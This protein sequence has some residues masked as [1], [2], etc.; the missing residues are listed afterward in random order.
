MEE[1]DTNTME[2]AHNIGAGPFSTNIFSVINLSDLSYLSLNLPSSS[3]K[4]SSHLFPKPPH[5]IHSGLGQSL[6]CLRLF[7]V[8]Y[9]MAAALGG[10]GVFPSL[11]SCLLLLF[12][13][14]TSNYAQS[15]VDHLCIF[16]KHQ[17]SLESLTIG[18]SSDNYSH[19]STEI[20]ET[21][22]LA[23]CS[24]NLAYSL[25]RL[26][27]LRSLIWRCFDFSINFIPPPLPSLEAFKIRAQRGASLTMD[28]VSVPNFHF[29]QS[30]QFLKFHSLK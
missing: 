25:T 7:N 23:L 30:H 22:D 24:E 26:K 19:A 2:T 17:T 20:L 14:P 28:D 1:D 6:R 3:P 21:Y 10:T 18:I 12:D 4:D 8:G 15:L 9:E 16:L 13:G 5:N 27:N 29:I 11:Y